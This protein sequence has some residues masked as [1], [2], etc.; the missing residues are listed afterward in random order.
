MPAGDDGLMSLDKTIRNCQCEN[1]SQHSSNP[2]L[3]LHF[4]GQNIY[5]RDALKAGA[6]GFYAT[7]TLRSSRSK[8]TTD[9]NLILGGFHDDMSGMAFLFLMVF[10]AL[11]TRGKNIRGDDIPQRGG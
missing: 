2:A 4:L 11:R 5:S 3:I 6:S 9:V 10:S 7:F 8:T 1:A